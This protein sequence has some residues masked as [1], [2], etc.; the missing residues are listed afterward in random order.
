MKHTKLKHLAVAIVVAVCVRLPVDA[1]DVPALQIGWHDLAPPVATVEN[2]FESLSIEQ[3]DTLR[4]IL[5]LEARSQRNADAAAGA[6][7]K[8]LRADLTEAGL[9][10]DGLFQARLDIIQAREAAAAAINEDLLNTTIRLPGY[11]LP[12]EF[13]ERKVVEFLLVP[14]VGAC[15]HTPPPPANQVVH[16]THPKGVEVTGLFTPVWVQGEL[17][18]ERSIQDV[19]Y[20]DGATAVDVSYRLEASVVEVFQ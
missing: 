1:Q 18:A 11:V 8:S 20:S 16:V 17:R 5:R 4:T 6:E 10:V 3:M 15:I 19:G 9:D 7:A 14:T 12:L 2:P 13:K